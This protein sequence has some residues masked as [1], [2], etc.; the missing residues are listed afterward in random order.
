MPAEARSKAYVA[1]GKNGGRMVNISA[2]GA[3]LYRELGSLVKETTSSAQNLFNQ[4]LSMIAVAMAVNVLSSFVEPWQT[5][6]GTKSSSANRLN[7]LN[8][9]E[10]S[11]QDPRLPSI[12]AHGLVLAC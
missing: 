7:P 2:R 12:I 10:K 9:L 5:I 3:P 1:I 6:F 8:I 4:A 11:I